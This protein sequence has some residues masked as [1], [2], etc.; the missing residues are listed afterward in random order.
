MPSASPSLTTL[1]IGQAVEEVFQTSRWS[2]LQKPF[3]FF[4][5]A[6]ASAGIKG[7]PLSHEIVEIC[8]RLISEP[9]DA[10]AEQLSRNDTASKYAAYLHAACPSPRDRQYLFEYM[11]RDSKIT[12]ATWRLAQLLSAKHRAYFPFRKIVLTTNFDDTLQRALRALGCDRFVVCDHP[13]TVNRI[14]PH[15]HDDWIRIV[16]LHGSVQSYD[17]CNLTGELQQRGRRPNTST[18]S[19]AHLLDEILFQ[20]SPFV[21]GYNGWDDAFVRALKRRLSSDIP[22]N[23]YWCCYG[24]APSS[25]I[26]PG[27]RYVA[28]TIEPKSRSEAEVERRLKLLPFIEEALRARCS[29]PGHPCLYADEVFETILRRFSGKDL[30]DRLA[31]SWIDISPSLRTYTASPLAL[32]HVYRHLGGPGGDPLPHDQKD[33]STG[34]L[35]FIL[36]D[37]FGVLTSL[38]QYVKKEV[39]DCPIRDWREWTEIL[40]DAWPGLLREQE[41][42]DRLR[43]LLKITLSRREDQH[44]PEPQPSMEEGVSVCDAQ[45]TEIEPL[46]RIRELQEALNFSD[47]GVPPHIELSRIAPALAAWA[48]GDDDPQSNWDPHFDRA[49]RVLTCAL[50]SA[51]ENPNLEEPRRIAWRPKNEENRRSENQQGPL[52]PKATGIGAKAAVHAN[53]PSTIA[54]SNPA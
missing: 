19:M 11:I 51:G 16:H 5:G 52:S 40:E 37:Y 30:S 46:Q 14:D 1:T 41:L 17:L 35:A 49:Q 36:A 24:Q 39:H 12:L 45:S 29:L 18:A 7:I 6:G 27:I 50:S 21:V 9:R 54:P 53:A 8:K 32:H 33:Y 25:R 42:R 26:H 31:S 23:P 10:E 3:F 28:P 47:G 4:L 2:G 48:S 22:F 43:S 13:S 15:D 34:R 38:E 20:A 44:S